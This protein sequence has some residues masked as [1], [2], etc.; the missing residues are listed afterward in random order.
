MEEVERAG[1]P[2]DCVFFLVADH[3]MEESDPAVQG[4]W[5]AALAEAGWPSATRGTGSCTSAI[6]ETVSPPGG[7]VGRS[8]TA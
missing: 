7:P 6:R 8:V 3:G 5:D 1:V 2:E 4:D